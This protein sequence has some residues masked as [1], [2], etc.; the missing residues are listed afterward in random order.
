MQTALKVKTRVL[1]GKR[2]EFTALEL[3]EGE[4]LELIVLR[5]GS[6][7]ISPVNHNTEMP[8]NKYVSMVDLL[9]ALPQSNLTKDDWV[10]MER[11]IQEE[12]E[13]WER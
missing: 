6:G 12:K 2:V 11:A 13:A 5:P 3:V 9:K 4:D 8:K 10:Q 7:P 1:S